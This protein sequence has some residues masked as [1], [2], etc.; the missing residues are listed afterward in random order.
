MA[1]VPYGSAVGS[2]LYLATCTRPDISFAVS[3]LCRFIAKP[4]IAHWRAVQHL[5]R[6]LQ[7][8]KDIRLVY[9]G[10]L[11]DPAT[12]F[13]AYSDSDHAGNPD[14]G[15]STGGYALCIGG[16]AVSWSSHLQTITA[17]YTTEAEYVAAVEAGKEIVWMCQLLSELGYSL[18]DPSVL[19]MDNQSVGDGDA[20]H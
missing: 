12:V 6:Y 7:G 10:A 14:N 9:Q 8:T 17:L 13:T 1:S 2:L 11:H 15:R 3:S 19:H 18:P 16:G 4:G 5:F 20:A